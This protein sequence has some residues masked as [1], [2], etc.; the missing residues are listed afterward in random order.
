MNRSVA[1][2]RAIIR[3]LRAVRKSLYEEKT[4]GQSKS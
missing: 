2:T 3:L 4:N 1:E